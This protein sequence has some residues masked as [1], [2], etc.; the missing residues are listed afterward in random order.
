[1]KATGAIAHHYPRPHAIL[2][3][4]GQDV[5]LAIT[6]AVL[7]FT[8]PYAMFSVALFFGIPLVLAFSIATLHFPSRVEIDDESISFARYGRVHRFAWRDIDCIRV[9]RFVMR[10][11]V[12]VRI[13][14]STVFRGRY[15]ILDSIE[16][17]SELLAAIETRRPSR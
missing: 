9:R 17:F 6:L 8:S 10:D 5:L 12:L 11:R 15:W 2:A 16:R 3:L 7:A 14:P 4:T 1:M 13:A